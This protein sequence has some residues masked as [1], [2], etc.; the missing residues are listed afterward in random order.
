MLTRAAT[1]KGRRD[2]LKLLPRLDAQLNQDGVE[3]EGAVMT[4]ERVAML[5]ILES[6]FY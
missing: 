1:F 5:R 4:S 2:L 6:S 3:P